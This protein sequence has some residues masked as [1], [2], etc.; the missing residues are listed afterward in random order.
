MTKRFFLFLTLFVSL[1]PARVFA[2]PEAAGQVVEVQGS[3][4]A[5]GAQAGART[6]QLNDP[7]FSGDTLRTGADSFLAVRLKDQSSLTLA[8]DSTLVLD[9]FVFDP[10][11]AKGQSVATVLR[12]LFKMVSGELVK[13]DPES[14]KIK[15]PAG[16]IGIRGTTLAARVENDKTLVVLLGTLDPATGE[17][18]GGHIT[19]Q[20]E[21]DGELRESAITE[22]GQ[23]VKIE[24]VNQ[25]PSASFEVPAEDIQIFEKALKAEGQGRPNPSRGP[26]SKSAFDRYM[27][28]KGAAGVG[29]RSA[30]EKPPAKAQDESDEA[31]VEEANMLQPPQKKKNE[32]D[33]STDFSKDEDSGESRT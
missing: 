4:K 21:V 12:G 20:N 1:L 30:E 11:N 16:T 26:D 14:V 29:Y 31:L 2:E 13:K 6:L 8:A 28:E 7:V 25:P 17:L 24:G 18:R 15:L 5:S 33:V 19:V 27:K 22:I 23:G 3:A 32:A 9:T 10:A